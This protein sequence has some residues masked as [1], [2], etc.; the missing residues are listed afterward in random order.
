MLLKNTSHTIL[1]DEG[2]PSSITLHRP[3]EEDDNLLRITQDDDVVYLHADNVQDLIT[4]LTEIKKEIN[5]GQ[6]R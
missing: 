3:P 5:D 2:G 4:A 6:A 1:S